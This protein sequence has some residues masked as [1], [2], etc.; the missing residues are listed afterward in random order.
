MERIKRNIAKMIDQN[1]PEADIDAYIASEG[2]TL[3]QL[4]GEQPEP[5]QGDWRQTAAQYARPA[6]E[7]GGMML[8]GAIGGGLGLGG[9]PAAPATVPA[10]AA[11]GGA[12]G[13]AGGAQAADIFESALGVQGRQDPQVTQN[14]IIN[15]LAQAGQ[16]VG[17]GA[18]MEMGGQ[19]LGKAIPAVARGV[20]K[21]AKPV[22]GRMSGTGT[23]NVAE[24]MKG[25]DDFTEAMRGKISGEKI[26]ENA[27][28]ALS[29]MKTARG[30]EYR[31]QLEKMGAS[32]QKLDLEPIKSSADKI[33][34]KYVRFDKGK[35]DW[36]RS[37]LGK[38]GSEGVNKMKDLY[39]TIMEWGAKEGDNTPLGVD[40]LKRQVDDLYGESSNSRAIVTQMRKAVKDHLKGAVPGYNK[41]TKGYEEATKLIKDVESGLMMRKQG[42]S[43][44]VVADQT[45][46]RLTS[47][48]KDNFALRKEL[49]DSLSAE[50]GGD[51]A[52]QIAG[53]NMSQTLPHGLA[54]TGPA[55]IAQGALAAMNP[56]FLAIMGASSPRVQGE[57]L[58]MLGKGLKPMAGTAPTAGRAIASTINGGE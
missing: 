43:G 26:V 40:M 1:A 7:F 52:A 17:R 39:E 44:R 45:L 13:Y 27:R 36:S 31:G 19:V 48:M 18:S 49:L 29:G 55:L 20:G 15:A 5:P 23:A 47:A 38:E 22:L 32:G 53:F 4:Q 57:F 54:G 37:A 28:T 14:A 46:R 58:S 24:A 35:P 11:A 2:V 6:L 30:A 12:L 33:F 42:M 3:G 41:M 51:L 25:A 56:K 8:G 50:G 9:G 21:V 16:D 10:A 34:K